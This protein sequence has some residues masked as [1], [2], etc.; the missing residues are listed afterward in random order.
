MMVDYPYADLLFKSS[1]DRQVVIQSDDGLVTI[2]NSD[3]HQGH[4][5]LTESLCSD[6]E[7]RFGTCEANSL[8][9]R[10][11]NIYASL[12]GKWLNVQLTIDGHTEEP[13]ILGH[14]RVESDVP[15]ADRKYRDVTAYDAMYDIINTD[16][17]EWYNGLTYPMTLRNFRKEFL[18]YFNLEEEEV[19]LANDDMTVEKTIEPSEISGKDIANAICEING[20]FGNINRYGK[21]EDVVLCEIYKGTYPSPTL[22]PSKTLFPGDTNATRIR[23]GSYI[24]VSYEDYKVQRINK[25]QI[26]QEENDIGGTYGDGDNACIVEGNFLVYGKGTEEIETIAE[27][28]YEVIKYVSYTPATVE[29]MGNPCF[30]LGDPV[31]LMTTDKAI[32]T[33]ILCRTLKG[34]QS[35]RDT[36][37]SKGSEYTNRNVNS[38]ANSIIRLKGKANVLTRT[39]EETRLEMTDIEEGLKNTIS[40]TASRLQTELTDTKNGLQSQITQTASAIRGELSSQITETKGY[41][42]NAANT[43]ESNAKNDTSEKLKSYSTTTQMNSAIEATANSITASV[44]EQITETITYING[45]TETLETK[46]SASIQVNSDKIASEVSRATTAEGELSTKITQTASSFSVQINGLNNEVSSIEADVSSITTQ[47]SG[48]DGRFSRIEQTIDGVT[49]QDEN[50]NTKISG[51]TITTGTIVGIAA[52]FDIKD[53]CFWACGTDDILTANL[54]GEWVCDS[55]A[56]YSHDESGNRSIELWRKD[57]RGEFAGDVVIRGISVLSMCYS[58]T[59]CEDSISSLDSSVSSLSS[60]VSSLSS[61]VSSVERSISSMENDISLMWSDIEGLDDSTASLRS[62][63]S[64]LST[65]ISECEGDISINLKSIIGIENRLLAVENALGL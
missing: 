16:M 47:I 58:V 32:D 54:N 33:Y 50:G 14:F 25:V 43:A 63:I 52:L 62:S 3:I 36:L 9:F 22:Y 29:I 5:E 7:L 24:E 45:K 56:L 8:K 48:L 42:S 6:S 61:S 53:A 28:L 1:V 2:T 31:R 26:R 40:I 11:S 49:F 4:F 55:N 30:V 27:K 19:E 35:S 17:A 12:K 64:S 20:C 34:V 57:G 44:N 13:L 39:I 60:S 41:A 15:T 37:E 23:S 38:V 51:S 21:W 18:K 10:I 65:R 59:D 46:L